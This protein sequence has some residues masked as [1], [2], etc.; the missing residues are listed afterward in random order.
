M[1]WARRMIAPVAAML[2]AG[3]SLVLFTNAFGRQLIPGLPLLRL[4][5]RRRFASSSITLEE[6]R[7]LSTLAT[8]RYFH[9]AVFPYDYLPPG[10][11][12]NEVLRKLRGSNTTVRDTLTDDEYLYLRA[13][14]LASDV[15]LS[16]TGGTFDF[17]VITLIITAGYDPGSGVR[18]IVMERIEGSDATTRRAVVTLDPP[19]IVDVAVEDIR[20]ADYPYPE[21]SLSPDGWRR[22]AGFVREELVEER[23]LDE[24]LAAA[25]AN[26]EAFLRQLVLQAGFAE[27][28]FE[29]PGDETY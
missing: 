11:S 14:N 15:R 27:V 28:R 24:V 1:R 7:E 2:I 26:G 22:I 6:V 8:V 4:Q 19:S 17:V 29:E 23:I 25:R 3:L 5:E 12:L 21:I 9:R 13:W 20:P 10:V 18:E 16:S